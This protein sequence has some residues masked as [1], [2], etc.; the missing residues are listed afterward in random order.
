MDKR[1]T[2]TFAGWVSAIL[3]KE[4]HHIQAECWILSAA[5]EGRMGMGWDGM[6]IAD[7]IISTTQEE[8]PPPAPGPHLLPLQMS[9][10]FPLTLT[11]PVIPF[12]TS[13]NHHTPPHTHSRDKLSLSPSSVPL[14]SFTLTRLIS[15]AHH[16]PAQ[17]PKVIHLAMSRELRLLC[18]H[19][20]NSPTKACAST[21]QLPN[22]YQGLSHSV[23][24]IRI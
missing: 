1:N 10:V 2:L 14:S 16:F 6:G 18:S 23:K 13:P 9:N 22:A 11:V 15:H 12:T 20:S 24:T 21:F 3:G 17:L 7:P 4:K 8:S 19:L 5:S